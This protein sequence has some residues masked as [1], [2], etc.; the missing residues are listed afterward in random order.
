[1]W[2]TTLTFSK[3]ILHKLFRKNPELKMIIKSLMRCSLSLSWPLS[4][5]SFSSFTSWTQ[6]QAMHRLLLLASSPVVSFC[7]R[8]GKYGKSEEIKDVRESN[9]TNKWYLVNLNSEDIKDLNSGDTEKIKA[10][11]RDI[12][13][14]REDWEEEGVTCEHC[15][16]GFTTEKDLLSHIDLTG[17]KGGGGCKVLWKIK[18]KA[19]VDA[20]KL[21]HVCDF[22]GCDI[23]F[24]W[25]CHLERHKAGHS[26]ER[27]FVCGECG[28][29]F[30]LQG[31]LD[32]RAVR[33]RILGFGFKSI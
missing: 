6:T 27:P 18:N 1:M 22:D 25:K 15:D 21:K 3:S 30:K 9:I 32:S 29:S 14:I 33:I 28:S 8:R 17:K 26:D 13:K 16:I 19:D 5:V 31:H 10:K 4:M 24:K 23:G 7:N 11:E 12:T 20:G 2:S